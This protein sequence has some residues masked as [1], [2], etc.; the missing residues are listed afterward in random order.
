MTEQIER[1]PA[2]A[3]ANA[4][5]QIHKE[6][7]GKGATRARTR[8]MDDVILVELEDVLTRA[9]Q[10]LVAAGR[11]VFQQ[12]RRATFVTAVEGVTGRTVRAFMSQISFNPDVAVEVFLLEP[13]ENS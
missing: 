5:V 1:S 12:A 11:E 3:I 6:A 10:T 13:E 2:V 7:Y 8:M 9:E 4:I